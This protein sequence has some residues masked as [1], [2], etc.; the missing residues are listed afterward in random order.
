ML[1]SHESSYFSDAETVTVESQTNLSEPCFNKPQRTARK[2]RKKLAPTPEMSELS[3]MSTNY[4]DD[5]IQQEVLG[6][7]QTL[8]ESL[9]TEQSFVELASTNDCIN[10]NGSV[11][12]KNAVSPNTLNLTLS[13]SLMNQIKGLSRSEGITTH[14]LIIELLSEGVTRRLFE[15][16]SRPAPSHLM[17]RNG[18]VHEGSSGQ[19][20]V[21]SHHATNGNQG[22]SRGQNVNNNVRSKNS[23][24]NRNQPNNRNQNNN[25]NRGFQNNNSSRYNNQPQ[26]NGRGGSPN[27]F[28]YNL[29][30]IHI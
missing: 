12:V 15:D 3:Y 21:M 27:N 20:P 25:F 17:T 2:S 10:N 6:G 22:N 9:M 11:D 14:D 13:W 26:Q 24:H 19:Q 16:Q 4:K 1:S 29:S 8:D 28:A 18:Y 7:E 23:F 5:Q 30:L